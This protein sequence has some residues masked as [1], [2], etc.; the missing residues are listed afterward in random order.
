MGWNKSQFNY[1]KKM[2]YSTGKPEQKWA[3]FV[4]NYT[5]INWIYDSKSLNIYI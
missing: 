3:S 5:N 4:Q 1:N 2:M